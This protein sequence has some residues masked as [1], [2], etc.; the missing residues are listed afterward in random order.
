M[1]HLLRHLVKSSFALFTVDG[2]LLDRAC[3]YEHALPEMPTV[4]EACAVDKASLPTKRA[5]PAALKAYQFKPGHLKVPGSGRKPGTRDA[6]SILLDSAPTK[7]KQYVRSTAPAVLVDARKWIM[8]V[9]SDG[10]PDGAPR[11]LIFI[12]EGALPR[13]SDAELTRPVAERGIETTEPVQKM[14]QHSD[15]P[16]TVR[17]GEGPS[18]T[19]A[20]VTSDGPRVE[21]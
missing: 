8:P 1:I 6:V 15:G 4:V 16:P 3:A 13:S 20:A 21:A 17:R 9:E 11:V 2:I 10:V 18:V 5:L 12:G 19:R 7:A 14:P